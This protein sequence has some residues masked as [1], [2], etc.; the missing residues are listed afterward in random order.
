MLYMID[1]KT[2]HNLNNQYKVFFVIFFFALDFRGSFTKEYLL[3][4][5]WNHFYADE[6]PS[7][8]YLTTNSPTTVQLSSS[9]S[10]DPALKS[11]IDRNVTF[12]SEL[13]IVLPPELQ[14]QILQKRGKSR[15]YQIY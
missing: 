3:L 8:V 13:K 1:L 10:L 11:Q 15:A 6:H 7:Y 9:D 2:L 12:A 5:M 4:I 14:G